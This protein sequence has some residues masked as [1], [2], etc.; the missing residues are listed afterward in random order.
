MQS[1][2]ILGESALS[3][4]K[5]VTV[6]APIGKLPCS[7]LHV[8]VGTSPELSLAVGV[9][10]DTVALGLPGSVLT[11]ILLGHVENDGGSSS[12]TAGK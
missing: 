1:D 7:G 10:Q 6:W 11:F 2:A 12:S 5:Q 4:A 9:V 8:T 3:L